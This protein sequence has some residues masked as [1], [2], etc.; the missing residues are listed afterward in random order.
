MDFFVNLLV[1]GI[2]VGLGYSLV[3]QGLNVTFWTV[4]VAN[5]AHGGLMMVAAFVLSL[6][7]AQG[8]P[9]IVS[10]LAGVAVVAV[11]AVLIE[12]LAVRP[13][14]RRGS[15]HGWVVS[16]LGAYIVLQGVATILWGTEARPVPSLFV[17]ASDTVILFGARISAQSAMLAVVALLI[18]LGLELAV[19]RTNTG[20]ILRSV[21]NDPELARVRGVNVEAMVTLSFVLSALLGAIAGFLI[22]PMT[23]VS[24]GFGFTFMLNG[25]AAMAV[26]G[27]GSSA[28]A[29]LGGVSIGVIELMAAGYVSSTSQSA[30][31]FV[32]L[33][34]V[35]FLRPQG[36]LGR[37]VAVK[38]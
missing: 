6:L 22:A 32:V 14:L 36:L 7:A 31:A 28:G 2:C 5:F 19:R 23:G 16:T 4:K 38:V 35:L 24:A 20:V 9:V 8:F 13:V 21:A 1:T 12:R 11:L 29:I 3:A 30:V 27:V 15:G 26:G 18:L 34:L 33:V 17:D 10:M 37:R 25:F